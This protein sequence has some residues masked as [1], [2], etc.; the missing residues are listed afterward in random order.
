M[1]QT[2]WIALP[3]SIFRGVDECNNNITLPITPNN[4]WGVNKPNLQEI[5]PSGLISLWCFA[6]P[7]T[8]RYSQSIIGVIH[9][10]SVTPENSLERGNRALV[11]VL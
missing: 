11:I 1:I 4:I 8:P 10:T 6:P 7:I 2:S 5:T 3:H 9:F